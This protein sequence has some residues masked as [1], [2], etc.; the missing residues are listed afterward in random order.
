MAE[1]MAGNG[2]ALEKAIDDAI[3][4]DADAFD[5]RILRGFA[6]SIAGRY[7]EALDHFTEAVHLRP[8]SVTA[9]ALLAITYT[10]LSQWTEAQTTCRKL[11]ALVVDSP[12]D[13]LFK[14]VAVGAL[15]PR[16]G[17]PLIDE[18]M[19]RKQMNLCYLYSTTIRSTWAAETADIAEAE[20]ALEDAATVRNLFRGRAPPIT[21]SLGACLYS[22]MAYHSHGNLVRERENLE[23]G[24]QFARLLNDEFPDDLDGC[25]E[26]CEL[27]VYRAWGKGVK[28]IFPRRVA[29]LRRRTGDHAMRYFEALE[30]FIAGRHREALAVL[31]DGHDVQGLDDLRLF[32]TLE[33]GGDGRELNDLLTRWKN[34]AY[35]DEGWRLFFLRLAGGDDAHAMRDMRA[36]M[37]AGAKLAPIPG[38]R[39][40]AFESYFRSEDADREAHLLRDVAGFHRAE[41]YAYFHLALREL[42]AGRREKGKVWLVRT[43][44]IPNPNSACWHASVVFLDRLNRD[45]TWPH[46]PKCTPGAD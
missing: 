33:S 23:K 3:D 40:V 19:K 35:Q 10:D 6:A 34:S 31:G 21:A 44:S 22:A 11:D 16:E 45:P 46:W 27:E 38:G 26:V 1:A 5:I 8:N 24:E 42:G 15:D 30:H 39:Q 13:L 36:R 12:E 7:R 25:S 41:I 32:A 9:H 2:A 28:P 14:G 20:R 17:L 4:L 29:D 43:V 37:Q 18:A